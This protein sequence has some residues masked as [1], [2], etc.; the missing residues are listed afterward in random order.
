MPSSKEEVLV[1]APKNNTSNAT[2]LTALRVSTQIAIYQMS[3]VQLQIVKPELNVRKWSFLHCG[4][5]L[6][7]TKKKQKHCK[8][9]LQS[10]TARSSEMATVW[11]R[12][13]LKKG[14]K[15]WKPNVIKIP[16]RTVWASHIPSIL[17]IELW[18]TW[19]G[20][21]YLLLKCKQVF[22]QVF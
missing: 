4:I 19:L 7:P 15:F 16:P 21:S 11:R 10:G 14:N 2:F 17:E 3:W 22:N 9:W 1:A 5:K 13:F 12:A 8:T 18:T 6:Q 20:Q